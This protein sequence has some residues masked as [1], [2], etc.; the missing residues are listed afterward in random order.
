MEPVGLS[1][2]SQKPTMGPILSHLNPVHIF[3]PYFFQDRL[4]VIPL[5]APRSHIL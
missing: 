3:I 1:A 4:Y 2:I 5:F